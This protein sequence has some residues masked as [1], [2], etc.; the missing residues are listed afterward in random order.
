ML[1]DW[2]LA[3]W[4]DVAMVALSATV[5]FAVTITLAR[6]NGLRS[7]AK[8]SAFDLV[9]TVA[10]GTVLASTL[11]TQDPPLLQ[12]AVSLLALFTL[13][14]VVARLRGASSA[15]KAMVDNDP[16]LLMRDGEFL[17]ENMAGARVTEADMWGQIRAANVLSVR[18]V[19]AVVLETTGDISVLHTPDDA[20]AVDDSILANVRGFAVH[21]AEGRPG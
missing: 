9:T 20:A 13:Q 18:H 19:R 6:L 5:I 17:R 4:G 8:M 14:H 16:V 7:F 3:G 15:F 10:M 12:G 11:A 1:E 21:G 2:L